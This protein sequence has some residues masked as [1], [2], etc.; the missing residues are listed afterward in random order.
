[1]ISV[2]IKDDLYSRGSIWE[3]EQDL[4]SATAFHLCTESVLRVRDNPRRNEAI[5]SIY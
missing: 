4:K 2:P 1:M 3:N 5:L